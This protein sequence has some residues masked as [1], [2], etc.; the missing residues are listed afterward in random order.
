M[1]VNAIAQ[2]VALLVPSRISELAKPVG[3]NL[4][5]GLPLSKGLTILAIERI[6][7]AVVLALLA[8]SALTVLGGAFR[9]SIQSTGYVLF[10][11][12]SVGLAS[13][14]VAVIWPTFVKNLAG[15][16]PGQWLRNQ[17]E[18]VVDTVSRLRNR[19]TG[20]LAIALTFLSWLAAYLIF[21]LFFRVLGA[22]D[23]T[24]GQ[25]LVVFVASTLG[26]I[27]SVAPGGMGTFEGAV[28]VSL[29]AFDVPL[30][31]AIT[32]A[33]LLR[34]CLV[35][36]VVAAASWFLVSGDLNLGI[37]LDRLRHWRITNE[38]RD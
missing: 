25:I 17:A 18:N 23:L 28:A 14:A 15:R 36:P 1:A 37:M 5:G 4:V 11:I 31:M 30:G 16:L 33:L 2:L 13:I 29:V 3:L 7:D 20:L 10:G 26:L 22:V 27:V 24:F 8:F 35:I 12:A 21:L 19:R 34:L 32:L 6:F 38:Q 9:T